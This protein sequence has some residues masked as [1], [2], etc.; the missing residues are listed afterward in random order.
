MCIVLGFFVNDGF[1]MIKRATVVGQNFEITGILCRAG[2]LM[3]IVVSL[4]QG[5]LIVKNTPP[6][7]DFD[8]R[9]LALEVVPDHMCSWW[10]RSSASASA[11]ARRRT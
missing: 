5:S 2:V 7:R 10:T 9:W 8:M 4:K 1:E 11:S 6:M 3:K